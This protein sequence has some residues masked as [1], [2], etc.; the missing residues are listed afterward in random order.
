MTASLRPGSA[1][2]RDLARVYREVCALDVLALKPGN[3]GVGRPG[4]GMRAADFLR[5]AAVSAG[6]LSAPGLPL[7]ERVYGAVAATRAAVGC[8]TN[9]GIIL[10]CAPLLQ[11][12][13]VSGPPLDLR[14]RLVAVLHGAGR[15][16]MDGL[17][18]A[19]RLAAPGG[20]GRA[21]GHDVAAPASAP[22][23]AVMTTAAARDGIA[24]QYALGFADLFERALPLC[25]RLLAR[26]GDPAWATAGVYLDLL[27]RFP[28][29]HIARKLG[30]A[31]A[32]AVSRRAAPLAAALLRAA[33]PERH[34]GALGA[35]DRRLKAAG[36]N[37]G[38]TA[39][40][41]VACLL[42]ERLAPRGRVRFRRRAAVNHRGP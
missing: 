17:N 1:A 27:R 34:R 37:P 8:N 7:G 24:R 20:L 28:D 23:L 32:R 26:W 13:L 35:L 42:I 22:P 38:T 41:T 31:R 10:L 12:A 11:A 25:R 36:I 6:P 2:R 40:L 15:H 5:S 4:H 33:H 19:I 14:R 39:D 21:A 16:D 18:R 3:V 30:A 9:L 29:T